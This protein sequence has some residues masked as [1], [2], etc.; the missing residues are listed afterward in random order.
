[1]QVV[2]GLLFVAAP[3]GVW[4]GRAEPAL[5]TPQVW[6]AAL[7]HAPVGLQKPIVSENLTQGLVLS[8]CRLFKAFTIFLNAFACS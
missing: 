1:M 8:S 7:P 5:G 2:C 3:L 6:D 4:A